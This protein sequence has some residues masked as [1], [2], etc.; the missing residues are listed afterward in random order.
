MPHDLWV[1]AGIAGCV[2]L[3]WLFSR[4]NNAGAPPVHNTPAQAGTDYHHRLAQIEAKVS[5]LMDTLGVTYDV[6]ADAQVENFLAR[7][8]KIEAIKTYRDLHPGTGLK[9]A[10]DAVEALDAQIKAKQP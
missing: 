7:G 2:L 5:F 8:M 10:K 1:P 3:L 6:P 9:E 4:R